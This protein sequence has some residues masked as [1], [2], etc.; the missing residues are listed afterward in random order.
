MTPLDDQVRSALSARTSD[1]PLPPGLL[2]GVERRARRMRRQRAGGAVAGSVLA[3]SLLAVGVPALTGSTSIVQPA[4]PASS[5]PSP[6]PTAT[7]RTSYSLAPD[8]PWAY[9]GDPLPQGT[10][11]T[12]AREWATA[13]RV[14]EGEVTLSPLYGEASGDELVLVFLASHPDLDVRWG[15]ARST[16]SG[17][18]L[19]LDAPLDAGPTVLQW[20]FTRDGADR[21]LAVAAP[22][23]TLEYGPDAAS[24]WRAMESVADGVGATD[25]DGDATADQVRLLDGGRPVHMVAAPS[26][27]G[28]QAGDPSPAPQEQAPRTQA[29]EDEG[30]GTETP[31][32]VDPAPYALDLDEPWAYRGPA[33]LTQHPELAVEDERLFVEGGSGRADGSWSQQPLLAVE[34]PDGLSVLVVLHRKGDDAVVTTTWQRQDEA[35]QQDEQEIVDGQLVVQAPLAQSDGSLVL[36]ALAAPRTGALEVDVRG[37]QQA[38]NEEG[39]S[40]WEL[41][42]AGGSG[43][44]FLYSEGDGLLYHSEPAAL[45]PRAPRG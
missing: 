16:E 14:A 39:F 10:A 34:R 1:L 44:L 23:T 8:A 24:E 38:S 25:L 36:V 32:D 26:P 28:T 19:A 4:P 17:P 42:R 5:A 11:E 6:S 35:A 18:E 7:A 30:P 41:P 37:A 2:D 29:P 12:V 43:K 20:A 13:H 31:V 3:V 45:E 33:E 27:P 9:R 21:L 22:G 40:V 15:V